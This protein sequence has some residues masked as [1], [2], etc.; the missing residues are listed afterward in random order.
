[1][2]DPSTATFAPDLM[3]GKVVLVTGGTSGLGAAT[4]EY[5][6]RL[7]AEVHAVGLGADR[8][9]FPDGLRVHLHELDVT[10]DDGLQHLFSQLDRL[11]V[12]VPAAGISL[13]EREQEWAAFTRVVEVQLLAAYRTIQLAKPLLTAS[14]HAS[15]ITIGSMYA[16]FG[17][18]EI[19]AYS[20]SKGG[21]VQLTKSLAQ[22]YAPD[23]IRVNCVA[24]GWIDT[25]LLAHLKADDAIRERLLSRTPLARFGDPEEIAKVVAFL[26]SDAASFV[27][28]A[29]LPVDGGYL[30]TGI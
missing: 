13:G 14:A 6:A 26:A 25:P 19:A 3:A 15:I 4:V 8:A 2:T 22:V 20:A 17:G 21:I 24:P 27:T 5:L 10:D 16:Y 23:G 18:G 30:V 29:V 1:M 7:G 11:D 28:G 9:S 12:L